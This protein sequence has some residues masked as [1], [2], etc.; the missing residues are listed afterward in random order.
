MF[1]PELDKIWSPRGGEPVIVRLM[2]GVD[3]T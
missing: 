2:E 3:A 1:Q